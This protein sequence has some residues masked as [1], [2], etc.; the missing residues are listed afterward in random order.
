MNV[1]V[2]KTEKP[3]SHFSLKKALMEVKVKNGL[4]LHSGKLGLY[5][6]FHLLGLNPILVYQGDR[7]KIVAT[8]SIYRVRSDWLTFFLNLNK[9]PKLSPYPFVGGVLGYFSYEYKSSLE[10]KGL[11]KTRPLNGLA[12]E[13]FLFAQVK[14]FDTTKKM[15]LDIEHSLP[16]ENLDKLNLDEMVDTKKNLGFKTNQKT[17]FQ[18]SNWYKTN[19]NKIKKHILKGNIY[20]A[21]LTRRVEGSVSKE[22]NCLAYRLF[23][24]NPAPMQAYLQMGERVIISTSPERFF[25]KRGNVIKSFPIKGTIKRATSL[26]R[27]RKVKHQLKNNPK[28]R[29]ELAMIVDLVQNDMVKVCTRASVN[30][31]QFPRLDSYKN[32]H[33]L[34]AVITG[35]STNSSLEVFNALFP[36][37]SVTGCPK[38]KSCQ[39]LEQI[40]KI[41]RGPYTGCLGYFSFNDQ[42]DFNILIRSIYLSGNQYVYQV[43]GGITLLSDPELE[44]QET[45]AKAE[46]LAQVLQGDDGD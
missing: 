26:K 32:V 25:Y 18:S 19:V 35:E 31:S 16:A 46:S 37:G 23:K 39:I 1:L 43:G 28:D 5:H 9:M 2:K 20:Q 17:T 34:Y 33:H 7:V 36:G 11:Y 22:P 29:A 6:R 38:I 42:C 21:N 4:L 27:D 40:E 10:E 44:W 30:V 41:P 24:T 12:T 15:F 8:N 3:Y 13:L 14:V 45:L